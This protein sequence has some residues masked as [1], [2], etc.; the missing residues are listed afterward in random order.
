M[1]AGDSPADVITQGKF[2]LAWLGPAFVPCSFIPPPVFVSQ[3]FTMSLCPSL[4]VLPSFDVPRVPLQA[5]W[6][7][8]NLATSKT[9]RESDGK[10][11]LWLSWEF[12]VAHFLEL[13]A[14]S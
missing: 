9:N 13:K 7:S 3:S 6:D 11:G 2:C 4:S 8:V 5:E 12:A 10:R 14:G 1:Q